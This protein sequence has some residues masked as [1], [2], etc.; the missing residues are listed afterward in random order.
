M[1]D[2]YEQTTINIVYT[3]VQAHF[4]YAIFDFFPLILTPLEKNYPYTV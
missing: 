4:M 2:K 3:C 1:L